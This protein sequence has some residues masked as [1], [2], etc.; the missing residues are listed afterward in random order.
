MGEEKG[1]LWDFRGP[2]IQFILLAPLPGDFRT[3][4][5]RGRLT[6]ESW[7]CQGREG[8]PLVGLGLGLRGGSPGA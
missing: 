2:W 1:R 6:A 4:S 7:P 5:L 8:A 3:Y